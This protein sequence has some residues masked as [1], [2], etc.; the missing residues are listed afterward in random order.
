MDKSKSY[1][2]T[3]VSKDGFSTPFKSRPDSVTGWYKYAPS[4]NDS[5]MVVML[6]HEGYITLPDHGTR[7]C[8]IGGVKLML[9]ST[10]GNNWVR[11]SAPFFYLNDRSPNSS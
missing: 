1:I 5:C 7:S 8:W 6:L 10:H 3:D 2:Y 4:E 9:P 11:F